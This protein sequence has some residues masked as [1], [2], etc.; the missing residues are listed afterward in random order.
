MAYT[1]NADVVIPKTFAAVVEG[2][3]IENTKFRQSG[4]VT[5]DPRIQASVPLGG[6]TATLPFWNAPAGGEAD[7]MTDDFSVKANPRKVTQSFMDTRVISR[8]LPFSAMDIANY[9]SHTDAMLYAA[10]EFARLYA[11]DEESTIIASLN[12]LILDNVANDAGDLRKVVSITTG[13]IAAANKMSGSLLIDARRQLGD[14]AS[15]LKFLVMHSDVVNNLRAAEANSFVPAS[16]T[17]IGMDTYFGYP[18][19]ETDAV[20]VDT[21][22]TNYPVYTS[23]FCAPG[24]FGY[25]SA[26]VDGAFVAVRDE[27]AGGGSGATTILGRRRYV[28]HPLGF[29]NIGTPA[30][31][32]SQ[33]NAELGVAA[34]WD[35]KMVR[36]MV[37][38]VQLK[39]NG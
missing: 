15:Q 10:G 3:I 4:I 37:P 38:L 8:V 31:N 9:A 39:T 36:K 17:D 16:K 6:F 25:G 22:V 1:R 20:G 13:T 26:P 32:V 24:L 18:I 12:G 14:L 33:T 11:S 35:R 34:T 29:S 7:S 21:T 30:N 23:Y 19:I 5:T 27:L 2:K 28:M